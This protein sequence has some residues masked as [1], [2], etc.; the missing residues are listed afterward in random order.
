MNSISPNY[1]ATL[2]VPFV[3][4]RDFTT[5][6]TQTVQHNDDSPDSLVPTTVII[7][8]TFAKRYFQGRDPLGRHIGFGINPGTK[9][10]MEIIGVVKDIKY[11]NL[12]D[13]IPEQAFVPYLADRYTTSMTVYLRTT[14]DPSQLY[15]SVRAKVRELDSNVP[16]Y[17]MRTTEEQVGNSLRSERLIGSLSAVFGLLATLMATIGLYGVMAYTVS[18]RK[19]EIGIRIALGAAERRVIWMV[20]KE[21]LV[22]VVIGLAVGIP[23]ALALTR[24]VRTQL[25][26]LAPNDPQTLALAIVGLAVVACAAGYIPALRASRIDPIRA[27]R[28]E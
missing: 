15:S 10:D 1:F 24:L 9:L 7:N 6:D 18:R 8:Q 28:Y 21:V 14:L 4:G 2:G 19:R 25:Y 26:G 22:L 16:I 27:L 3:S 17:A 20:M 13:E 12:R 11:T 5:R 23:A